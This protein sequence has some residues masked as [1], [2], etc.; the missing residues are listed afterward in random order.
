MDTLSPLGALLP[1]PLAPRICKICTKFEYK[2]VWYQASK[3]HYRTEQV[4]SQH[5][6]TLY[7]DRGNRWRR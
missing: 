5:L 1:L 4:P 6:N 7:D 2:R 3:Q